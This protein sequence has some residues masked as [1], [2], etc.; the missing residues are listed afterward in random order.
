MLN[1]CDRI[2]RDVSQK[3]FRSVTAVLKPFTRNISA[4][5]RR[6]DSSVTEVWKQYDNS[7]AEVRQQCDKSVKTREKPQAVTRVSDCVT[8]G[9][10]ISNNIKYFSGNLWLLHSSL[11]PR[12]EGGDFPL[13]R[14]HRG[15]S[16]G[17]A[18][19]TAHNEQWIDTVHTRSEHWVSQE[20]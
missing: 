8:L 14:D 15:S 9:Y 17:N 6:C 20:S 16:S 1:Q 11:L 10:T 7:S 19:G 2:L 12:H 3:C 18:L 4:V 5:W 13:P